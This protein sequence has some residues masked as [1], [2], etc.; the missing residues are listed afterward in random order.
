[1]LNSIKYYHNFEKIGKGSFSTVYKGYI[2]DNSD[3]VAIKQ[4]NI[5]YNN[6]KLL[7]RLN[8]E[9]DIMKNLN[10]KNIIKLIDVHNDFENDIVYL[11]MEYCPNNNLTKFI[12]NR[13][14]KEK[15]VLRIMKQLLAG[16]KYLISNN[17]IH[18]DLK[19]QNILLDEYLNVKISDFGFAKIFEEDSLAQTLCGSPLYMAPEI[20]KYKKYSIKA[21]LWSIGIILY[22]LL[23]GKPPYMAKTHIELM[24]KIE[25]DSI[26]IPSYC[27]V[28]LEVQDLIYNLLQKNADNRISWDELFKH[29]WVSGL[30]I[31]NDIPMK[32]LHLSTLNNVNKNVNKSFKKSK[33]FYSVNLSDTISH[34]VSA[35][36]SIPNKKKNIIYD[37]TN[38]Y[39]MSNIYSVSPMFLSVPN[40]INKDDFI[41]IKRSNMYPE[42]TYEN[43]ERSLFGSLYDYMNNSINFFKTYT[44][45]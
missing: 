18:R 11:I 36:I 28:S 17:I 23:V 1:M 39:N 30:S 35:P 29:P 20:M 44:K 25:C 3:I 22:E 9:I 42:D 10:H 38:N 13:P 40:D 5:D 12:K 26:I 34:S 32:N 43:H 24:E 41:V 15:H 2:K 37:T 16:L 27:N 45:H 31:V 19:P 33:Q 21:D 7:N 6:K 8:I 14:M 4:I